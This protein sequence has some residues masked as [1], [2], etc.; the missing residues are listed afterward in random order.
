[1][2][3]FEKKNLKY[4]NVDG[5]KLEE[6][7]HCV[8]LDNVLRLLQEM[9]V[10]FT[11]LRNNELLS[12]DELITPVENAMKIYLNFGKKSS[13]LSK[14]QI[15][16][17]KQIV[18]ES[19]SNRDV[20]KFI[21]KIAPSLFQDITQEEFVTNFE[22]F[23]ERMNKLYKNKVSKNDMIDDYIRENKEYSR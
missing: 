12:M 23:N 16:L 9:N 13:V 18:V 8:N 14:R 4:E 19:Q 15:I 7:I 6:L 22:I 5:K 21:M 1:M 3:K 2:R 17:M 10:Y 20:V 11:K